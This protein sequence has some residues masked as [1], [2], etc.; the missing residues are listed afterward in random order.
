VLSAE[1]TASG[2][3]RVQLSPI[4]FDAYGCHCKDYTGIFRH[5]S[6]MSAIRTNLK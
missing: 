1:V 2:L 3:S 4:D 6:D 5:K